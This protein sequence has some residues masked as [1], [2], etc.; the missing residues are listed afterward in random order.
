MYAYIAGLVSVAGDFDNSKPLDTFLFPPNRVCRCFFSVLF[1][2]I[3]SL[4]SE[5]APG[6]ANSGKQARDGSEEAESHLR[7]SVD[8]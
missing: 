3:Q 7:R 4:I 1:F 6:Y 5:M 8:Y 2:P